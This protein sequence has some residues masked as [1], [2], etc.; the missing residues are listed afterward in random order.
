[1]C[2]TEAGV[3]ANVAIMIASRLSGKGVTMNGFGHWGA[4]PLF[5]VLFVILSYFAVSM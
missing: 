2:V 4:D 5:L 1:M 3:Y